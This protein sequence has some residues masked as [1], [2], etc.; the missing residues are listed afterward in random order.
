MATEIV[1]LSDVEEYL[2]VE[3]G[4]DAANVADAKATAEERVQ[5]ILNLYV[6]DGTLTRRYDPPPYGNASI[7]IPVAGIKTAEIR[8]TP[9]QSAPDTFTSN[10]A[11]AA[12]RWGTNTATTILYPPTGGWTITRGAPIDQVTYHLGTGIP[13]TDIKASWRH[14]VLMLA[15]SYYDDKWGEMYNKILQAV[16]NHLAGDI[17]R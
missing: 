6:L 11:S 14:A 12:L 8:Q 15:A 13:S 1:S 2:S 17:L 4:Q 5:R 7:V 16:R 10:M 9:D 3:S